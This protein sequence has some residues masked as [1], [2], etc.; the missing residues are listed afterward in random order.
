MITN[1]RE[2]VK[3]WLTNR[4]NIGIKLANKDKFA[5]DTLLVTFIQDYGKDYIY[6]TVAYPDGSTHREYV[7]DTLKLTVLSDAEMAEHIA[8]TD[9]YKLINL[10]K[11]LDHSGDSAIMAEFFVENENGDCIPATF[12]P[13]RKNINNPTWNGKVSASRIGF[14]GSV[15]TASCVCLARTIDS[16][17]FGLADMYAAAQQNNSEA[18]I[19]NKSVAILSAAQLAQADKQTLAFGFGSELKNAYGIKRINSSDP[20]CPDAK[21]IKYRTAR[22]AIQFN[23]YNFSG[24]SDEKAKSITKVLDATLGCACVSL[25]SGY[26]HPDYSKL[27]SLPGD[28]KITNLGLEYHALSNAWLMHP[29]VANLVYDFARKCAVLGEK[30]LGKFWDASED[31]VISCMMDLDVDKSRAIMKR[32]KDVMMKMFRAA[33]PICNGSSAAGVPNLSNDISPEK[34]RNIMWDVFQNGVG[35][36]VDGIGDM[37]SA[38]TLNGNW[39]RHS[40]GDGKNVWRTINEKFGNHKFENR[41][42]Y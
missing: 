37:T 9:K 25:L 24:L 27:G 6:L 13:N 22:G 38:W 34:A 26:N 11:E 21:T 1:A 28:H 2:L 32:N 20:S 14:G 33:W 30:G 3:D 7:N 40:E 8:A 12:L 36:L 4:R 18:K 23:L 5:H 19:S 15:Q 16:M 42:I 35:T 31:E 10:H 17:A 29:M 41:I 39:I